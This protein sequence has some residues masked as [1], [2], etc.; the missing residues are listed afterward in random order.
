PP[1]PANTETK[2]PVSAPAE[3]GAEAVR[4]GFVPASTLVNVG[5]AEHAAVNT[6]AVVLPSCPSPATPSRRRSCSGRGRSA[7]RRSDPTPVSFGLP[8]ELPPAPF[9]L[10]PAAHRRVQDVG[11]AAGRTAPELSTVSDIFG[12]VGGDPGDP[13]GRRVLAARQQ[14][15]PGVPAGGA[16]VGDRLG[17]AAAG[18]AAE[19][20]AE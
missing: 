5:R 8:L 4:V 2:A 11:G 16:G 3:A 1:R 7:G 15:V 17:A 18:P 20:V 13:D 14:A 10:G 19:Q 6:V 9:Q 12:G